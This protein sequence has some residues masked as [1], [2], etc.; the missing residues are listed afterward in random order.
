MTEYLN[1]E[2]CD[3]TNDASAA[4]FG[5]DFQSNAG[6][7]L[8]LKYLKEA[9]SIK[10]ESK[11][12]DIEISLSNGGK[13]LA[14]AKSCQDYTIA[15]DK[16][17][18]FKD[19]L[20]SLAKFSAYGDRLIYISNIP[21]TLDSAKNDFNN[22]IVAYSSC[23]QGIRNEIDQVFESTCNSIRAKIAKEKDAKKASKMA[24]ILGLVEGF[25]KS[26]LYISV[27]SPFWGEDQNRYSEISNA[28]ISFLVDDLRLGNDDAR[29]IK[30]KLLEHWQLK[31]QHNSSQPDRDAQ[32]RITK[33]EFAWPVAVY[34][35]EDTVPEIE[36]CLSFVPDQ[37]LRREIAGIM[38]SPAVVYHERFEF[39]NKV[40]QDYIQFRSSQPVGTEDVEKLFIKQHGNDYCTEFKTDDDVQKTEYLTKSFIFRILCNHKNMNKI[41]AGIGVK[42]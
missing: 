22:K 33:E 13:I 1:T 35:T 3:F 40:I 16:K 5:W 15:R 42:P 28:I 12:Q 23:L 37:S 20:I 18:R 19:A 10:I 26:K 9:E 29:A 11:L 21:D 38:V 4:S 8:F 2:Y 34:L 27:I 30:Q 14:Q 6:I 36:D 41:S 32:K 25:D 39:S 31:C 24:Q 17:E 7:F